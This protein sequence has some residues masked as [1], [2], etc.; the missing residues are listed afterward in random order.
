LVVGG[1][2]GAHEA[3]IEVLGG[4]SPDFPGCVLVTIHI[5]ER[6]PS[7]LPEL[8]SRAGPLTAAYPRQGEHLHQGRIY[9]APPG[10]HFLATGGVAQLSDGP[11]VNRHRPAIDVMFAS[12]ARWAGDRVVAMVL[13]GALDDGAVGA[14]LIAQA[15]GTVVVQDPQL[16]LFPSMPRAAMVAAGGAPAVAPGRMAAYVTELLAKKESTMPPR[17]GEEAPQMRMADS[18]DPRYLAEDETSLTRLACPECGGGLAQIQLPRITYYRCHVGHQ[19]GPQSLAAAQLDSAEAKLWNAVA[20]LEESAAFSRHLAEHADTV[21]DQ[22][23]AEE[24]RRAADRAD[25]L[26]TAIRAQLGGTGTNVPGRQPPAG[27]RTGRSAS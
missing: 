16:A 5:G 18:S 15:G 4:L 25:R 12:A 7:R 27:P 2:A 17:E 3:L 26:V 24:H 14:A 1:S 19:Y 22:D 11:R 21:A 20:A 6:S 10:F 9:V 23:A 8:L 13:S